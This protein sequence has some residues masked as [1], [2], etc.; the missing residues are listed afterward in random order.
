MQ[1]LITLLICKILWTRIRVPLLL[2][3]S[4]QQKVKATLNQMMSITFSGV[5]RFGMISRDC[6]LRTNEIEFNKVQ[7][8]DIRSVQNI[9]MSRRRQLAVCARLNPYEILSCTH[10]QFNKSYAL[11]LRTGLLI[12]LLVSCTAGWFD[13]DNY[14]LHYT[15]RPV[16][17]RGKQVQREAISRNRVSVRG[18]DV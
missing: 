12:S 5:I 15:W 4:G 13:D 14:C 18:Y 11:H 3:G 9:A 16:A 8:K 10:E 1:A 7:R 6:V 17:V 2:I